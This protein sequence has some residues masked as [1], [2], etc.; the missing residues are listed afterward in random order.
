MTI[1][2]MTHRGR[3][4]GRPRRPGRHD[5][6]LRPRPP[7]RPA[8]R[9]VGR[10]GRAL[11]DP[12]QRRRRRVRQVDRAS[13]PT[14][15]EPMV[16]YGNNPGMG[17]P[18]T[19]RVPR[20]EDADGPAGAPRPRAG[21][22]VHG[23]RARASRSPATRSTSCSSASCTNSRISDL[24]ARRVAS[25]RTAT[26]PTASR[27]MIVPGLA[28][29]EGAGRARGPPRDLPR[30][31][32][33]VARGRLLDVH[34]DE[35]RPADARASTP[36]APRNRNFEGRQGKG[37]RTFLASPL[38][39]AASAIERQ[40]HRPA[41]AC[42]ASR[43][44]SPSAGATEPMAEPFRAFASKVVPLPRGERRHRPDRPRPLPQ[45]HRQGGPRGRA[46]PRLAVR[47]G[48]H[49]SRTRRSSWT[50]PRSAGRQVLLVGDN[51]G[52]GSSREH[53][54]WALRA[55]ASRRSCRPRSPTSSAATRSR[56]ACCRSWSTPRPTERLF[57]LVDADPDA[58]AAGRPR[59]A[60]HPPARRL[61]DRLRHRPVQQDDA[62]R[63]HRRDRLRPG[64]G[65]RRSRPGRPRTRRASTPAS[66][67]RSPVDRPAASAT[68]GVNPFDALA[69]LVLVLAVIAGIRTGALPQVGG[70]ARRGDRAA[71][72]CSTSRP[73]LIDLTGDLEPVPPRDRRDR[74][75]C[76]SRCIA[77]E[78]DRLGD[79]PRGRRRGSGPACCR[80]WT[81]WPAARSAPRRRC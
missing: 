76:S 59:R 73:W 28:A 18:I 81:A 4:A 7:A 6:R 25:S 13:T 50:G 17:I 9:G 14:A 74:R 63:R 80:G 45:G 33:R 21:A 66:G 5:V 11:A 35:R 48:R 29:G 26:S 37:G 75:R 2:N 67:R 65:R 3:R 60:G 10:G 61:D 38:T 47:G 34:R 49:A 42:P 41:D 27:L 43:R 24:R 64:Q 62:A 20:P 69:L 68:S 40:G 12:A 52:T 8:G 46:V 36:S 70:I 58:R 44:W 56:T 15:L 23:P 55:G 54:P 39:A 51:F 31:G 30:R 79:R 32:R 1:C 22:R 57:D 71:G 72:R 53:A 16:T 77:G 78:A 19:G